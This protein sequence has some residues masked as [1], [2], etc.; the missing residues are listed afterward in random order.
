MLDEDDQIV[1]GARRR[2][3]ARDIAEVIADDADSLADDGG[4]EDLLDAA[5]DDPEL[6]LI[7][8]DGPT[9]CVASAG[10][11]PEPTA[12]STTTSAGRS[13]G[14]LRVR[15][16]RCD[17]H[18]S[19]CS[20][21][22]EDAAKED[23]EAREA[24]IEDGVDP[25]HPRAVRR[26]RRL[27]ARAGRRPGRSSTRTST[28]VARRRRPGRA[29]RRRAGFCWP[30][31]CAEVDRGERASATR[32]RWRLIRFGWSGSG[33]GSTGV[34]SSRSSQPSYVSTSISSWIIGAS[35]TTAHGWSSSSSSP[36]SAL[37]DDARLEAAADEAAPRRARRPR[38]RRCP[39]Q[40]P[41]STLDR[42]GPDRTAAVRRSPDAHR[43]ERRRDRRARRPAG[44]ARRR[45]GRDGRP[46][47]ATWT[48]GCAV[49]S[50]RTRGCSAAPSTAR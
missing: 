11:L 2:R 25:V 30:R 40:R 19:S 50:A 48:A 27:R 23:L 1:A 6:A 44:G 31:R 9:V 32:S 33:S 21:D 34:S 36:A 45:P 22:S 24:L 12:P 10:T 14:A 13:A 29:R 37:P 39:S 17:G 38:R 4:M 15:R 42:R 3:C 35:V 46:C 16:R 43:G 8:R 20:Y 28:T 26:P 47:S 5:E 49:P 41:S 7:S 18:R